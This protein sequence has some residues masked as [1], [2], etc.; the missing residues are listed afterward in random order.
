MSPLVSIH[1]PIHFI[2]KDITYSLTP[3]AEVY[4]LSRS[5]TSFL[6]LP[7]HLIWS[8]SFRTRWLKSRTEDW[9]FNT[10]GCII[11]LSITL[12]VVQRRT[13]NPIGDWCSIETFMG[14]RYVRIKTL[15]M[16]IKGNFVTFNRFS[17]SFLFSLSLS[18]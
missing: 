8:T 5:Y 12:T 7:F 17:S 11:H 10:L 6:I 15:Y 14:F 1:R 2:D 3:L 4:K 16:L 13:S 9:V 18:K